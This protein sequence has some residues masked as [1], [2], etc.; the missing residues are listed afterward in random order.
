MLRYY[1]RNNNDNPGF[2]FIDERQFITPS[3]EKD[4]SCKN[5][6]CIDG[7]VP[8]YLTNDLGEIEIEM[9]RCEC[10]NN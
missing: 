5:P 9:V 3:D 7:R 10:Y 4:M 2:M 1:F 6:D 8:E